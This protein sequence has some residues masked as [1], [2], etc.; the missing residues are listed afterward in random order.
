M[1]CMV[2]KSD[3]LAAQIPDSDESF[4]SFSFQKPEKKYLN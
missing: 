3:E 4:E 2:E 1:L